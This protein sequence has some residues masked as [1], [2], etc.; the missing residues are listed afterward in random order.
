MRKRYDDC[1]VRVRRPPTA[2]DLGGSFMGTVARYY[3]TLNAFRATIGVSEVAP[4]T[5]RSPSEDDVVA[6]LE[7]WYKAHKRLPLRADVAAIDRTPYLPGYE[8]ILRALSIQS[9]PVAMSHV[10]WL[11]GIDDPNYSPKKREAA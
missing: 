2:Q 1:R 9:W 5:K 7:A 6:A 3:G 4:L 11:L 10:A 8:T